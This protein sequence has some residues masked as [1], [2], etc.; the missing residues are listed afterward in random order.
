MPLYHIFI[1]LSSYTVYTIHMVTKKKQSSPKHTPWWQSLFDL[2]TQGILSDARSAIQ[3]AENTFKA[4]LEITIIRSLL[5]LS[6]LI[7]YIFMLI[8]I[9]KI[10]DQIFLFPGMGDFFIGTVILILSFI[11]FSFMGTQKKK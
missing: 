4:F 3:S 11:A 6:C 10:L 7:G 8:G 5:L 9:S 1:V 2:I